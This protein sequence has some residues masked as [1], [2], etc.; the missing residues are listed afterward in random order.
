VPLSV[1][2]SY[3]GLFIRYQAPDLRR[4]CSVNQT[5]FAKISLALGGFLVQDM[6]LV[7][8]CAQNLAG[9]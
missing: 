3:A 7:R 2:P 1:P 5:D 9:L 6:G 4:V 8:F